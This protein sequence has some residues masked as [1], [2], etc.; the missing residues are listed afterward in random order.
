METRQSYGGNVVLNGQYI[1]DQKLVRRAPKSPESDC[2]AY[3]ALHG[4][5]YDLDVALPMG[6]EIFQRAGGNW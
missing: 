3:N 6:W 2:L 5:A 4:S 1:L